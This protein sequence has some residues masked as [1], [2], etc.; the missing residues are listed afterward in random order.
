MVVLALMD[1][2]AM[3]HVLIG[4]LMVMLLVVVMVV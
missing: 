4:Y 1:M 3:N 2:T